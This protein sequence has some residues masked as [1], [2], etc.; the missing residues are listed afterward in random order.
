MEKLH[1]ITTLV[2]ENGKVALDI[3]KKNGGSMT[4]LSKSID[5]CETYEDIIKS[6]KEINLMEENLPIVVLPFDD[7]I[8]ECTVLKVMV[9]TTSPSVMPDKER[10]RFIGIGDPYTD[11]SFI[12]SCFAS[13]C[14][15]DTENNIFKFICDN[16]T[17]NIRP[18]TSK[19][20]HACTASCGV[21]H[22]TAQGIIRKLGIK[23]NYYKPEDISSKITRVWDLILDDSMPFTIY[24]WKEYR[25]YEDDENI[26][27]HIGA[28]SREDYEKVKEALN[29]LGIK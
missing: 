3:V 26:E 22:D 19:D 8:S 12:V 23:P 11:D 29:K 6:V 20:K 5:D 15:Y 2:G 18:I 4:F 17:P 24:D 28:T 10:L 27:W 7:G 21:V 16:A 1:D 9:V 13:E 14:I 25:E